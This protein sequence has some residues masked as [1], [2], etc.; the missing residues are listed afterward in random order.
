MDDFAGNCDIQ[1]HIEKP[2]DGKTN[3]KKKTNS[4]IHI[5]KKNK[6]KSTHTLTF[7]I[8]MYIFNRFL[9]YLCDSSFA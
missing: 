6:P 8:D 1:I 4:D 3:P 2:P 9:I 5:K 7:N